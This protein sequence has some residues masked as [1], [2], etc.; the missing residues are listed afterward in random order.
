MKPTPSPPPACGAA[1]SSPPCGAA[2]SET[3]PRPRGKKKSQKAS[4]HV[5]VVSHRNES[6]LTFPGKD[7]AGIRAHDAVVRGV[8]GRALIRH[9]KSNWGALPTRSVLNA[10]G[11][12][13]RTAHRVRADPD[14]LLG[15]RTADGIYRLESVRALAQD[16]LGSADSAS[17]WLNTEAIGLEFRKPIDLVSTSPGTEAVKTLLQ[18]MRYGVY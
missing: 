9:L 6:P 8:S 17:E 14:R 12:S 11:L 7:L 15:S 10:I 1:R 5:E 13:V 3:P 18:R 2:S 4:R 16:V